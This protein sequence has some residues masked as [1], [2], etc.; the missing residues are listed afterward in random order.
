MYMTEV[1]GDVSTPNLH[2]NGTSINT[3]L[4]MCI[5]IVYAESI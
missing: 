2:G 1:K 4:G 3:L 5:V